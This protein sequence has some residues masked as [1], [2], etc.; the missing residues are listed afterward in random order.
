MNDAD[1]L[2]ASRSWPV[3]NQMAGKTAHSPSAAL[4]SSRKMLQATHPGH[5]QQLL[6]SLFRRFD[7]SVGYF[8][9]GVLGDKD[10]MLNEIPLGLGALDEPGHLPI[11]LDG[12][13]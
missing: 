8:E 7:E 12:A 5:S 10:E 11:S 4:T 2:N 3:E 6:E 13:L 9:A 1:D